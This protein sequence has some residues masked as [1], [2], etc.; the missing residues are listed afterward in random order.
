[1]AE[2]CIELDSVEIA[3]AVFGNCDR[4]IR[5]LEKSFLLPLFAAVHSC[6]FPASRPMWLQRT[7]LWRECFF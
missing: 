4:N 1:M 5:L 3:A 6:A 2:K 7:A